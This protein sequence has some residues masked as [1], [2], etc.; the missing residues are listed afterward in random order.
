MFP[1]KSVMP[2]GK[3]HSGRGGKSPVRPRAEATGRPHPSPPRQP[4]PGRGRS[5]AGSSSGGASAWTRVGQQKSVKDMIHR[6]DRPGQ[7]GPRSASPSKKRRMSRERSPSTASSGDASDSEVVPGQPLTEVTLQRALL[8]MADRI[9]SD[10]A[11]EFIQLREDL[12]QLHGRIRELEQHVSERDHHIDNLERRISDRDM[13]IS[14]LGEEVDRLHT[15]QRR[16]DLIFSG[17]AIPSPPTEHWKEDVVETAVSLLGKSMPDVSVSRNDIEDAFRIGK[18]KMIICKFRDAGKL[19]VRDR[20]YE[21]R[22]K[23]RAISSADSGTGPKPLYVSENLSPY[24]QAILQA[25]VKEKQAKKL[26]TV[27]SQNGVVFCKTMQHGRKI[28]VHTL[29]MIPTVLRE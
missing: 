24:R 19:S 1:L 26:Y 7:A 9:K 25:L 14:E 5:V 12:S 10:M 11:A 8:K 29:E 16:K 18:K 15:E 4:E 27:F 21:E 17:A 2:S 6:L 22:F 28:R 20:I 3:K 23:L 13:R